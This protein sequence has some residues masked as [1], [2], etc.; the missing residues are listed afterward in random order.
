M[1][2]ALALASTP[3]WSGTPGRMEVWSAT[4]TNPGSGAG[5]WV[6]FE[7]VAP[8]ADRAAEPYGHGWIALFPIDGPPVTGRFGPHSIKPSAAGGPWFDAAGCRAE[9]GHWSGSADGID[10]NLRWEDRGQPLWTFPK[11][12]WSRE[13]LPGA[14][15]LLAPTASFTG[16]VTVGETAHSFDGGRGGVAHIYGHGNADRWGWVHADLGGGDVLELVS[17]VSRK[18]VLKRL[19]ALAFL[20]F[21]LDGHDWPSGLLPSVRAKTRLGLPNWSVEGRV[22]KRRVRIRISQ[23]ADR[24]VS[25]EYIDP[26]GETA[27]CT[28]T[29]RADVA[30][31]LERRVGSGWQIERS[32]R[33]DGTGHAE[34]G[35]RGDDAPPPNERRHP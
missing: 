11:A 25:L 29:E 34:V 5:L 27:V 8:T 12:A 20:R 18:P 28:N 14:Q 19:P 2:E 7:L 10:W 33:L 30:V 21:R 23:P 13:L 24:C 1:N 3:R 6:H 17:G 31:D 26:N 9:S 35:L 15:V 22:G 32:W 16:T 4:L